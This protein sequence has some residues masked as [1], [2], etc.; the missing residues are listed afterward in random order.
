MNAHA[1]NRIMVRV[2]F[3]QEGDYWVA[4][5]IDYDIAA[6]GKTMQ[7]TKEAFEKTIIGQIVVDIKN[8][9]PPLFDIH[10]APEFYQKKFNAGEQL[11]DPQDFKL[12]NI[13]PGLFAQAYDR[14]ICATC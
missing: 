1:I 8:D 3:M 12:P 10:S 6:Q 9:R 14:R 7:G 2:L 11:K 13:M 5:C 4:Q